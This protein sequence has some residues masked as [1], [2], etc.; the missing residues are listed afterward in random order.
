MLFG[1]CFAPGFEMLGEGGALDAGEV[2]ESLP[3][4]GFFFEEGENKVREGSV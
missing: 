2:C 4:G 1:N 3:M